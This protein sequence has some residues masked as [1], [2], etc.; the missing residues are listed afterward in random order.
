MIHDHTQGQTFDPYH[1]AQLNADVVF[2]EYLNQLE[3][4]AHIDNELFKECL[5]A[6]RWI[7]DNMAI[8]NYDLTS[9]LIKIIL[10]LKARLEERL[11]IIQLDNSA[12]NCELPF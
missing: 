6:I 3:Y 4:E 10:P 11:N 7:M 12:E 1:E 2:G 9:H 5:I 8:V